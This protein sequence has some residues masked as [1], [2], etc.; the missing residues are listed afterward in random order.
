MTHARHPILT[1][2]ID[3][4][5]WPCWVAGE[6]PPICWRDDSD[7]AASRSIGIGASPGLRMT[8]HQEEDWNEFTSS[9]IMSPS[10]GWAVFSSLPTY[11]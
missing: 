7:G 1:A 4:S 10:T 11:L 5:A 2:R 3:D 8:V 9:F 6:T